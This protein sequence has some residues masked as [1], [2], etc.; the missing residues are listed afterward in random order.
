MSNYKWEWFLEFLT[1]S[2]AIINFNC[3]DLVQA[4]P[5]FADAEP[6]FV[7]AIVTKLKFEVFLE[8]DI[9]IREGEMGT[10]MYFLRE[11]IVEITIGD[12]IADELTEGAYFGG[13][14]LYPTIL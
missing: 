8:G 4:V 7:S 3:R 11:G 9:I 6:D 1:F 14:L 10:E 13:R 5:F 12:Q 2:K